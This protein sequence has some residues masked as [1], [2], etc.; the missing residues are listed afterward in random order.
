MTISPDDRIWL[1]WANRTSSS[2][3]VKP[4]SL[5]LLLRLLRLIW[6]CLLILKLSWFF[7][8][9]IWRWWQFPQMIESDYTKRILFPSQ[10]RKSSQ[11]S[12][13]CLFYVF[14]MSLPLD[15]FTR[16]NCDSFLICW[17]FFMIKL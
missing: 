17:V 6:V 9:E 2:E 7:W 14:L 10:Q 15:R 11:Y 12:D 16:F 5:I 3:E 4:I 8:K 1:Y 13:P